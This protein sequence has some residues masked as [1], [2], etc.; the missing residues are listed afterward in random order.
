MQAITYSGAIRKQD[1]DKDLL[2]DEDEL[3]FGTDPSN[4]DTDGDGI[5]DGEEVS[6]GFDPL[7]K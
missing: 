3:E 6:E 7:Q 4:S 2:A 5:S 1:K